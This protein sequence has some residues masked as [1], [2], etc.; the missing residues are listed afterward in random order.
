[1]SSDVLH[2]LV[3]CGL[4]SQHSSFLSRNSR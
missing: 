2:D 4:K 3:E 1:M